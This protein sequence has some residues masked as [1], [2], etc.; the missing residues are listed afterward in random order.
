[1]IS[2]AGHPLLDFLALAL[3][4]ALGFLFVG[5]SRSPVGHL[6]VVARFTALVI[7]TFFATEVAARIL[8]FFAASFSG[9]ATGAAALE[10]VGGI[11]LIAAVIAAYIILGGQ[12]RIEVQAR[13]TDAR[14]PFTGRTA[15]TETSPGEPGGSRCPE[16]SQPMQPGALFCR[17][18]GT[19]IQTGGVSA[20][21]R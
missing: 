6:S 12:L 5:D 7:V 16:C 14:S 1:M 2:V 19:R 9:V 4:L 18:C 15:V 8:S 11:I 10:L 17:S 13:G 21:E 3:G 20:A